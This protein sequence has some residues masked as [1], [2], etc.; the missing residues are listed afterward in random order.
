MNYF[1]YSYKIFIV[2]PEFASNV[3]LALQVF[4]IIN[5]CVL[6]SQQPVYPKQKARHYD[7]DEV[8]VGSNN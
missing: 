7:A 3:L 1:I 8:K 4:K 5:V 6:V 2:V